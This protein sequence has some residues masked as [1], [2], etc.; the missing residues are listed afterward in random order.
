MIPIS[1]IRNDKRDVT[2]D[3]AEIKITVRSYY[4]HP[5]AHKLENLGDK[6]LETYTLPRLNQEETDSLQ[7]PIMRSKTQSV[8]HSLPTKK[9]WTWWIHSW[10]LP[11]GQRR[12]GTIPT[13]TIPKKYKRRSSQ[14]HSMRPASSWYQN[15]AETQQIKFQANT[16]DEHQCEN[17]Q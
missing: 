11:D 4:E 15:L 14:T 9:S 3:S 10:I 1:T 5:Y 16:P 8:I 6:F 17:P 13:E 7:G 12:A 2:T